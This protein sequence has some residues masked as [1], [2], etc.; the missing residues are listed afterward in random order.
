[1]SVWLSL[2]LSE[3]L[4]SRPFLSVYRFPSM[5]SPTL[6]SQIILNS[7]VHFNHSLASWLI[8]QI[9]LSR[10]HSFSLHT[11]SHYYNYLY[12]ILLWKTTGSYRTYPSLVKQHPRFLSLRWKTCL[13]AELRP[14]FLSLQWGTCPWAVHS[15]DDLYHFIMSQY[16]CKTHRS[17]PSIAHDIH[18]SILFP[19]IS[20]LSYLLH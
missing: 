8:I 20:T 13:W 2:W 10:L 17:S 15:D 5:Y 6:S 12:I 14:W 4:V 19:S 7:S 16:I 11:Y 1:M 3:T 9:S 18:L